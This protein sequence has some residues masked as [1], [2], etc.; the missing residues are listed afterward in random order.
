[1]R[2]RGGRLRRSSSKLIGGERR[3]Q[4]G[5]LH[6][7]GRSRWPRRFDVGGRARSARRSTDQRGRRRR[8][9]SSR[10]AT[11]TSTR[12]SPATPTAFQVI[13]KEDLPRG[14]AQRVHRARPAA[15]AQRADRQGRRRPGRGERRGRRGHVRRAQ[16]WSR[17]ATTRARG[18]VLGIIVGILVYI[19]ILMYGS[20]VAQG[21]VEEKSSRI[22]ELLL[23]TIR[24]WQLMVGKVLGIGAGRAARRWWSRSASAW[25]PGSLLDAYHVPD[26]RSRPARRSGR[27]SGSCSAT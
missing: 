9:A 10:S 27:W 5:R 6:A 13:V 21:V 18:I 2:G 15:R 7:V 14:P 20:I 3:R 4:Q 24:P 19:A 25:R 12:W 26:R 17:R 22:V 23:T 8:P 1:M 11:A 16:R